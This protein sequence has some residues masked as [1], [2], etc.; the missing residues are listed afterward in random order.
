MATELIYNSIPASELELDA[1][2]AAARLKIP[3]R[4]T[5]EY[6]DELIGSCRE[7]L[8]GA[9][10]CRFCAVKTDV[11]YPHPERCSI[12]L[13]FGEFQSKSLYENLSG[14]TKAY[15]FA[16]TLGI[17]VDRLILRLSQ[18][19]AAEHFITDALASAY[20]ESACDCAEREI[21]KGA[22][23][24]RRYSP[25]YGDLPLE[26]QPQILS[27]LNAGRLLNISLSK[28]LLMTPKKSVTAIAGLLTQAMPRVNTEG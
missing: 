16:V 21:F 3:L 13:G 6:T 2:E 5:N 26:L 27:V 18:M 17:N 7:R 8:L 9:I 4:Y 1:L 12:D 19:S 11:S 14:C 24:R 28:S 25:G 15:I 23:H 20:A 10:D 22:E